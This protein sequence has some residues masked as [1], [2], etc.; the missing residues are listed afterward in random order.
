MRET[1]DL[2]EKIGVE[3]AARAMRD[4]DVV[5]IVLDA[6]E[7]LA[8]ED[9][10]L[11][12]S[13]DARCVA[14]VNKLDAGDKIDAEFISRVYHVEA[15]EL[16]AVTGAGVSALKDILAARIC[17]GEAP[18]INERHLALVKRAIAALV[19][20]R[21]ALVGGFPIDVCAVDISEALAALSEITGENAREAV[22]DRVFQDFCVGK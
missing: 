14:C 4:A 8:P 19:A 7:G 6:H 20:A 3:R 11:L 13:A 1:F 18:L 21:E 2:V 10:K 22:I 5:L 16:S 12:A 9:E 15:V 17:A